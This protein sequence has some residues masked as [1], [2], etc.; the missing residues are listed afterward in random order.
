MLPSNEGFMTETGA[1][2]CDP[3]ALRAVDRGQGRRGLGATLLANVRCPHLRLHGVILSPEPLSALCRP[4]PAREAGVSD[5][6]GDKGIL[7]LLRRLCRV[8]RV[9]KP[10]GPVYVRERRREIQC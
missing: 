8:C 4:M 7:W 10:S 1:Q 9:G 5:L 3:V 6:S 2:V